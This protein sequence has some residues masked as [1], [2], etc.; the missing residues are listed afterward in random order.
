MDSSNKNVLYGLYDDEEILLKA[1]K[2]ARAEHYDIMNVFTPFP[3]H[4]LED[5]MGLSESPPASG[6]F[7][8]WW[9]GYINCIF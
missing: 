3:V 4:G 1:I 6:W 9:F 8:V 7:R 2:D 5:A